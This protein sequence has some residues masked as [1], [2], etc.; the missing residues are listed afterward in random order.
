MKNDETLR[1]RI[2]KE[3]KELIRTKAQEDNVSISAF[4]RN[5]IFRTYVEVNK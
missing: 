4:V 3:A 5:K 1:L 2:P